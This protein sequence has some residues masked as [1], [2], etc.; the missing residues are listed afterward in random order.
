MAT[1][2]YDADGDNVEALLMS[3]MRVA[4][5]EAEVEELKEAATPQQEITS[6]ENDTFI[7]KYTLKRQKQ[8]AL[9]KS[10]YLARENEMLSLMLDSTRDDLSRTIVEISRVEMDLDDARNGFD[11]P[12]DKPCKTCADAKEAAEKI[13]CLTQESSRLTRELEMSKMECQEAQERLQLMES[14][15]KDTMRRDT[16]FK[17]IVQE[18]HVLLKKLE[19]LEKQTIENS[20]DEIFAASE[21]KALMDEINRLQ[22]LQDN[23]EQKISNQQMLLTASQDEVLQLKAMLLKRDSQERSKYSTEREISHLRSR[24]S[25]LEMKLRTTKDSYQNTREK[26]QYAEEERTSLLADLKRAEARGTAAEKEAAHFRIQISEMEQKLCTSEENYEEIKEKITSEQ[27]SRKRLSEQ[28]QG[29]QK[30]LEKKQEEITNLT[31]Q[32]LLATPEEEPE[33]KGSKS[34]QG[35]RKAADSVNIPKMNPAHKRDR[36]ELL[37]LR[38]QVANLQNDILVAEEERKQIEDEKSALDTKHAQATTK[39][40]TKENEMIPLPGNS[41]INHATASLTPEPTS[42]VANKKAD[43]VLSSQLANTLAALDQKKDQINRLETQLTQALSHQDKYVETIEFLKQE[44][45]SMQQITEESNNE[46]GSVHEHDKDLRTNHLEECLERVARDKEAYAENSQNLKKELAVL[47]HSPSQDTSSVQAPNQQ[48]AQMTKLTPLPPPPPTANLPT[49]PTSTGIPHNVAPPLQKSLFDGL[50]DATISSFSGIGASMS[51]MSVTSKTIMS[52][53]SKTSV[54]GVVEKHTLYAQKLNQQL[55]VTREREEEV[56][57]TVSRKISL[58]LT[59]ISK[60]SGS[61]S[62]VP[63]APTDAESLEFDLE[64]R[65]ADVAQLGSMLDLLIVDKK[66]NEQKLKALHGANKLYMKEVK[67]VIQNKDEVLERQGDVIDTLSEELAVLKNREKTES[68]SLTSEISL[69]EENISHLKENYDLADKQ[70]EQAEERYDMALRERNSL[71]VGLKQIR[72]EKEHCQKRMPKL[73]QALAQFQR[74]MELRIEKLKK[75]EHCPVHMDQ[76]LLENAERLKK[77]VDD[78]LSYGDIKKRKDLQQKII[79][80]SSSDTGETEYFV[81]LNDYDYQ[82]LMEKTSAGRKD[83]A[84]AIKAAAVSKNK[85]SC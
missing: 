36:N 72:T 56:S 43:D 47:K 29:V 8:E 80:A 5:L 79:F 77:T 55:G 73:K 18:K 15:R 52:L 75:A 20:K 60:L 71:E 39:L 76:H 7:D 49:A 24:I 38:E 64:C 69:L 19:A 41:H 81:T 13:V 2:N 74:E 28:L 50:D 14:C 78:T 51:D 22:Q 54:S 68:R 82:L 34:K 84:D 44:L 45:L 65:L 25:D 37:V 48:D 58:L 59:E 1:R 33:K 32:M 40:H 61:N 23:T 9:A 12:T 46:T 16:E 67:E 31:K 66:K 17:A 42:D 21:K 30:K 57:T 70:Q 63:N 53:D 11:F 27:E 26:Y 6:I 10:A 3:Q 62:S 35:K 85:F 83:M 4:T